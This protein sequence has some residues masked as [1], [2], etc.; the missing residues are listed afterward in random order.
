MNIYEEYGPNVF[1]GVGKSDKK[2]TLALRLVA[3]VGFMVLIF[4]AVMEFAFMDTWLLEVTMGIITC[5]II[6]FVLPL[7]F[8]IFL[9]GHVRKGKKAMKHY[10]VDA[11]AIRRFDQACAQGN[12]TS[13]SSGAITDEHVLLIPYAAVLPLREIVHIYCKI[14][15][16]VNHVVGGHEENLS[17]HMFLTFSNGKK[18]DWVFHCEQERDLV[19]LYLKEHCPNAVVENN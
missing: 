7:G 16:N 5:G 13:F 2:I 17:C 10:G 18:F 8:S 4:G 15:N 12:V 1:E 3:L 14:Y 9:R 6:L 19:A 11:F